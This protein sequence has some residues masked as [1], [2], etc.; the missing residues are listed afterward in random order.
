[1]LAGHDFL[2][3]RARG[4]N[5]TL[6]LGGIMKNLL[7]ALLTMHVAFGTL[8][9]GTFWLPMATKKGGRVHRTAGW[10]FTGAMAFVSLTALVV[11]L[12]RLATH[13]PQARLSFLLAY[14]SIMAGVSTWQGIRVLRARKRGRHVLDLVFPSLLAVTGVGL[15]VYGLAVARMPLFVFFGA[16]GILLATGMLRYWLVPARTSLG[17]FLEHMGAMNGASIMALTAFVVVN[18]PRLGLGRTALVAWVTPVI[19]LG[20]LSLLWRRRYRRRIANSPV[21]TIQRA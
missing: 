4:R 10:I 8:A 13:D 9:L 1:M 6:Q 3:M 15:T 7:Q 21:A 2:Q 20:A 11:S 16:L 19:V 12:L 18:A 17:W 14:L 5:S